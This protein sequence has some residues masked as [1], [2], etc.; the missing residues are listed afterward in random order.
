[1]GGL[2]PPPARRLRG[3]LPHLLYSMAASKVLL[4]TLLA[5]SWH[6]VVREA[7]RLLVNRDNVSTVAPSVAPI[8]KAEIRKRILSLKK[9]LRDKGVKSISL[10]GSTVRGETTPTSDIDIF[11]DTDPQAHFSLLD[12]VGV[13][14]FLED[15]LGHT[16]D[17][18]TRGGLHPS[19]RESILYESER[20]F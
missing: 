11:I 18:A 19:I 13:K 5:P 8:T 14:H 1:M 4:Q 2:K 20:V 3:A 9:P 16:V 10:F 17:I 6:T 15:S 12:L 7:L